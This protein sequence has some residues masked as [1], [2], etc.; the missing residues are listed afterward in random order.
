[1]HV[2]PSFLEVHEEKVHNNVY[3]SARAKTTRYRPQ[4]V[5]PAGE[6]GATNVMERRSQ[7]VGRRRTRIFPNES[8]GD[9]DSAGLSRIRVFLRAGGQGFCACVR[10]MD[11][12]TYRQ[13]GKD[14][15][16]SK[17]VFQG[18]RRWLPKKHQWRKLGHLFD[19]S[20]EIRAPPA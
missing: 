4:S 19:A 10:C 2:Q 16:S 15:G 7:Y 14:P 12:T 13:L 8:R 5:S 11:N 1:M 17:T 20:E 18:S 3:A 9:H 6:R